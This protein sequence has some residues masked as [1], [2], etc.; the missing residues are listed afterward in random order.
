VTSEGELMSGT[1]DALTDVPDKPNA[2]RL[3][4]IAVA[5]LVIMA[6]GL[7]RWIAA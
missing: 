6:W 4:I 2:R 5:A 1:D 7:L 3:A